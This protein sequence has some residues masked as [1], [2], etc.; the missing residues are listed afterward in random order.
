MSWQSLLLILTHT[1]WHTDTHSQYL[2]APPVIWVNIQVV[3]CND[4]ETRGRKLLL[5][6]V[7]VHHCL[8]PQSILGYTCQEVPDNE[9]IQTSFIALD[10]K[11]TNTITL[12]T[13]HWLSVSVSIS[14]FVWY[15]TFQVCMYVNKVF[16]HT[17]KLTKWT[18]GMRGCQKILLCF[19][20][21]NDFKLTCMNETPLACCRQ[22]A[23]PFNY[24]MIFTE[25]CL[26]WGQW[27]WKWQE[28][29]GIE[30]QLL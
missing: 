7:Y 19:A 30:L 9:L 23:K 5:G 24:H 15:K 22:S 16:I 2:G 4:H 13:S 27:F 6:N 8:L 20:Q 25:K 26:L 21:I 28:K 29:K 1:E 3:P 10:T 14:V 12:I 18:W 11:K 17:S